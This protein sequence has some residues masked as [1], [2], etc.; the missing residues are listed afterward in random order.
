[1]T[2][3]RKRAAVVVASVVACGCQ[4][5]FDVQTGKQASLPDGEVPQLDAPAVRGDV[6][7]PPN[8]IQLVEEE[9]GNWV[10][11]EA[12][13]DVV[14]TQPVHA[15]DL[16]LITLAARNVAPLLVLPST[17]TMA[18]VASTTSPA[19]R[20]L[21]M[22]TV[23]PSNDAPSYSVR[24]AYSQ[25]GNIAASIVLSHYTGVAQ[26][27]AAA[28]SSGSGA[29]MAPET[30]ATF[31]TSVAGQ[32]VVAALTHESV[33]E[34][35]PGPGFGSNFNPTDNGE[36]GCT[37]MTEHEVEASPGTMIRGAATLS[38]PE[39]WAMVS[40]EFSPAP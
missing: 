10:F 19:G 2:R 27:P 33:G 16:I 31:V 5:L 7:P 12:P 34:A 3:S 8:G 20:T 37:M 40:A 28:A 18:V 14:V 38:D 36:D 13:G 22:S 23:V 15:G 6:A 26:G 30:S 9:S 24:V 11:G 1:M 4:Q 25:S 39:G 32:L 21:A 35:G 29:G 17:D